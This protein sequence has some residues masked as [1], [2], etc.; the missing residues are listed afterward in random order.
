MSEME[1]AMAPSNAS[2]SFSSKQF[3]DTE[4]GKQTAMDNERTHS[5]YVWLHG[6]F[7]TLV[8]IIGTGIL[9]F[10]F[11][12][13]YLGWGGGITLLVFITTAS[14]YTAMLLIGVQ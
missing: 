8:G 3:V 11:A 6:A 14:L 1:M 12:F 2:G 7:H 9:G 10:P 4:L 13:A 5:P